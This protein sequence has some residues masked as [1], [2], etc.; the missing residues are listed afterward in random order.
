M[1]YHSILSFC[2]LALAVS[3]MSAAII[4][5][6]QFLTDGSN[7]TVDTTIVGQSPDGPVPWQTTDAWTGTASDPARDAQVTTGSL[8]Y[9]SLVT[10]G[11]KLDTF[12]NTDFN[13]AQDYTRNDSNPITSSTWTEVYFSVLVN[14]DGAT[15]DNS[16]FF[17]FSWD[18]RV[19]GARQFGFSLDGSTGN[20]ILANQGNLVNVGNR[21]GVAT[22][23]TLGAG[24]NLL[25]FRVTEKTSGGQDEFELWL[26]PN[27]ASVGAADYSTTISNGLVV[28]NANYGFENIG[29][30]A[31]LPTDGT[32]VNSV[33]IDEFRLGTE[34]V[35][36]LPVPEPSS[37]L[38]LLLGAVA[39]LARRRVRALA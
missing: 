10:G 36:V 14:V 21:N 27:L 20:E 22:G 6:D 30:D 37:A 32:G 7:Y 3:P 28:N 26:N 5:T 23:L 25:L 1:K 12:R 17:S 11:G 4:A 19:S 24:D 38:L 16:D 13:G 15:I 8:G 29:I 35:D 33:L 9:G 39:L 34:L 2:G 18:H 31:L